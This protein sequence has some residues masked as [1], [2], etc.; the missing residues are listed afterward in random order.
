MFG[1]PLKARLL[2][3]IAGA[4][5]L[6]APAHAQPP[7]I[8]VRQETYSSRGS[9]MYGPVTFYGSQTAYRG[10]PVTPREPDYGF[11]THY[12]S[13]YNPV[14]MTSINYPG[15]YGSLTMGVAAREYRSPPRMS[16]Y[17]P[18]DGYALRDPVL[19]TPTRPPEDP[20]PLADQASV[21][22]HVPRN[23]ELWFQ[24]ERMTKTGT[25]RDFVTPLLLNNRDYTYDIRAIWRN[26]E[27]VEVTRTRHL[28]VR[29]GDR[30]EVDFL[31]PEAQLST[32]QQPAAPT[33]RTMPPP[34][35][36]SKIRP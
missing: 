17:P 2:L 8:G 19:A 7:T 1:Y 31:T 32:P 21:T 9:V 4:L 34:D 11:I 23:A 16:F 14:F 33:L 35:P 15:V 30:L 27:G 18:A 22:V 5:F 13:A 26:A 3:S 12:T 28:T 29:A 6:L 24:G 10:Y 36:R 25:I 20:K